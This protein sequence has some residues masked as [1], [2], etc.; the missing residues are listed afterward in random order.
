MLNI[1]SAGGATGAGC[2]LDAQLRGLN[3]V[4]VMETDTGIR[5]AICDSQTLASVVS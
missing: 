2:A 1:R 5:L 4:L 3:T